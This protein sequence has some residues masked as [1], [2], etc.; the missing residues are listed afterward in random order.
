MLRNIL[1]ISAS[2]ILAFMTLA[3]C[4]D[5][6]DDVPADVDDTNLS[7][8]DDVSPEADDEDATDDDDETVGEGLTDVDGDDDATNDE[9]DDTT[10]QA[11]DEPEDDEDHEVVEETVDVTLVDYEIDMPDTVESGIVAFALSNDGEAPHG[12]A[13]E[14]VSNDEDG[15]IVGAMTTEPGGNEQV[16]L[17]LQPGDYV[18]F[19]PIGNHREDEGM[20][21]ELA[22]E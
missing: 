2:V 18:V 3:A 7:D 13:I 22:V 4:D 5:D 19:C 1:A 6:A 20:E 21:T 17:E 10:G 14:E 16:E 8:G 15:E 12:I 9:D 11:S